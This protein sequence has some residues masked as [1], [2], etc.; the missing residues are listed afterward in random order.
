MLQLANFPEAP[1]LWNA[2]HG[3]H[4]WHEFAGSGVILLLL[5]IFPGFLG[6]WLTAIALC[7][8][9]SVL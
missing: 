5:T 4:V 1:E 9:C 2:F 6:C 7:M 8:E 3:L